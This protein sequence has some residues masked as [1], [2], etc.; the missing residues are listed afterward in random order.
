[1]AWDRGLAPTK[2]KV[3]PQTSLNVALPKKVHNYIMYYSC[4][5]SLGGLHCKAC[6]GGA[7]GGQRRGS[8]RHKCA[9]FEFI[10]FN[11]AACKK[12]ETSAE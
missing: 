10:T 5:L 12:V 4:A 2:L 11:F 9:T 6:L 1:V 8:I 3:S 7:I